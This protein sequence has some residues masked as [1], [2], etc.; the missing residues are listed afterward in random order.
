MVRAFGCLWGR[1]YRTVPMGFR[2]YQKEWDSK[3]V[4][5]KHQ[6]VQGTGAHT[7][8]LIKL[9]GMHPARKCLIIQSNT[10]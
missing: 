1:I 4:S 2:A 9:H 5:P 3:D 10:L 8:S 6:A 7:V